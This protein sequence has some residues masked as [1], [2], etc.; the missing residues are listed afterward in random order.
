MAAPRH[1]LELLQEIFFP[2]D[3]TSKTTVPN[4]LSLWK[5]SSL[6]LGR[7]GTKETTLSLIGTVHPL[8]HGRVSSKAR[9][10]YKAYRLREDKFHEFLVCI[11]S[12][13]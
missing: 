7:F 8:S 2:N 4:T 9:P 12:L 3:E 11:D 5:S 13:A 6:L 10:G 1:S